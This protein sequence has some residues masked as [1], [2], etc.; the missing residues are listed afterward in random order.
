MTTLV[1]SCDTWIQFITIVFPVHP[2]SL[3][4][5]FQIVNPRK[6]TYKEARR[7]NIVK[8]RRLLV[9][10]IR[11][12]VRH[13]KHNWM[14]RE[15]RDRTC[16][17]RTPPHCIWTERASGGGGCGLR[18]S[19]EASDRSFQTVFL[20]R[21]WIGINGRMKWQVVPKPKTDSYE[22]WA[23]DDGQGRADKSQER[24]SLVQLFPKPWPGPSHQ[25]AMRQKCT[26]T[27]I[28]CH[29]CAWWWWL[30]S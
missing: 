4:F 20:P 27:S 14:T 2:S 10:F 6:D 17:S 23:M 28:S 1:P 11:L 24:P 3:D 21:T 7:R 26:S 25:S 13:Q 19:D 5:H 8:W 12:S 29:W 16:P 15:T 30:F 18:S 9:P 22:E